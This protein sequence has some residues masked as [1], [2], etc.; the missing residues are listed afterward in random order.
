MNGMCRTLPI[1]RAS[2]CRAVGSCMNSSNVS[3]TAG[4]REENASQALGEGGE[5]PGPSQNSPF[6][7][8]TY[9]RVQGLSSGMLRDPLQCWEREWLHGGGQRGCGR[10]Q[11]GP[12]WLGGAWVWQWGPFCR[13]AAPEGSEHGTLRL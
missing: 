10:W 3:A 7:Q 9:S 5:G 4:E 11:W 12:V 2:R 8:G 6:Q 13:R 1:L